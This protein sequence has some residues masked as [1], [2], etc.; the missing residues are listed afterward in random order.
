MGIAR[1]AVPFPDIPVDEAGDFRAALGEPAQTGF[2]DFFFPVAVRPPTRAI[3]IRPGRCS[4]AVT[5]LSTREDAPESGASPAQF[6]DSMGENRGKRAGI[7]RQNRLIVAE[8]ERP[9]A[10]FQPQFARFEH[11]AIL[12]AQDGQQHLVSQPFGHGAPVD[13]EVVGVGRTGTVFRT[14]FHQRFS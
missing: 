11:L 7:D 1:H 14:L 13:V 5:M 10:V 3:S 8:I 12:L 9:L 2:D 6:V 4:A